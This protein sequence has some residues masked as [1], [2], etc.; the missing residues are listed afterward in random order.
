MIRRCENPKCDSEI[1]V[2]RGAGSGKRGRKQRFCSKDCRDEVYYGHPVYRLALRPVRICRNPRCNN[3]IPKRVHKQRYCCTNCRFSY[4][5]H[6]HAL[7]DPTF[8]L[9][10]CHACKVAQRK[11]E[12]KLYKLNNPEIIKAARQ[13]ENINRNARYG[14]THPRP[15]CAAKNCSNILPKGRQKYCSNDCSPKEQRKVANEPRKPRKRLAPEQK[16]EIQKTRASKRR[17]A[18]IYWKAQG[19]S[20]DGL[21]ITKA[22]VLALKLTLQRGVQL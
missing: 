9:N 3:V 14:E 21:S 5:K 4:C 12:R 8:R 19:V 15:V 20:F 13:R 10:V 16:R 6:C 17:A 22:R 1:S 18:L 11:E 2:S 7:L